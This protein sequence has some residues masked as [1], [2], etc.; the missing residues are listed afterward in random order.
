MEISKTTAIIIV[1]LFIVVLIFIGGCNNGLPQ[2]DKYTRTCLTDST[3]CTFVRTPVDYAMKGSNGWES[4]PHYM[5]N[6]SDVSQ[7]LEFGTP[8]FY[9]DERKLEGNQ[10]TLF[11]QYDNNWNGCGNGQ[12]YI[13]NDA[14][15]RSLLREMGDE[16][17]R[18]ILDSMS[19]QGDYGPMTNDPVFTDINLVQGDLYGDEKLYGGPAYFFRDQPPA[20]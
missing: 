16:T 3:N 4:Y 9:K 17:T 14:K 2:K 15:T 20:K 18:R 1:C 19:S 5:G 7:P 13:V 8:D 10:S 12:S 11:K 6:P